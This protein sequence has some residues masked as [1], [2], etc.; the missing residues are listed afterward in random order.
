MGSSPRLRP[1]ALPRLPSRVDLRL[2]LAFTPSNNERSLS[3]PGRFR[4]GSLTRLWALRRASRASMVPTDG[5]I[6][7][8]VNCGRS[9][10]GPWC[11][12]YCICR[13]FDVHCF[14]VELVSCCCEVTSL[15]LETTLCEYAYTIYFFLRFNLKRV[16]R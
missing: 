15:L 9:F 13:P 3:L 11:Y 2:S 14:S 1:S 10:C 12:N 16:A 5:V 7:L 8:R 4:R 6:L